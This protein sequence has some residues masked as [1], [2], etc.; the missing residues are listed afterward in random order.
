MTC[1]GKTVA[2]AKIWF[3]LL[4]LAVAGCTTPPPQTQIPASLHL[5]KTSFA[6]LPQW[7]GA[8]QSRAQLSFQRSC[9]VLAAKPDSAAMAGAG[10][11]GT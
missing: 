8:E 10:Y 6:D 5:S 2:P 11:A 7:N 3:A 4:L 1:L 9:A